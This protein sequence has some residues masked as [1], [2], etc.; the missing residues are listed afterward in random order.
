MPSGLI[1][2]CSIIGERPPN[3]NATYNVKQHKV[4][5]NGL[6]ENSR[7]LAMVRLLEETERRV[8]KEVLKR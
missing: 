6:G 4:V 3:P 7:R 5:L 1:H 2:Y 8:A